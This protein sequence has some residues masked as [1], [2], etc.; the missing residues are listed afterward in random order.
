MNPSPGILDALR[1]GAGRV[2]VVAWLLL[3]GLPVVDATAASAPEWQSERGYRW[4]RVAPA[5]PAKTGFTPLASTATGVTFTN[6]LSD[7]RSVANRNLLSGA[8][9]AAGDV[10]GDGLCDLYYCGLDSD[11]R[12]FRNLGGWKFQDITAGASVACPGQDSTGAAFADLEGDGDLDLLVTALGNGLRLFVNDGRGTFSEETAARGVASRTGGMSMAMA[13]IDGD[14]DLDLYVANYYPTTIRDRPTTRFQVQNLDGRPRIVAVDG[15]STAAPD[16]TN[17]FALSPSGE[18]V[19]FSEPDDLFLNDG[20]GHFSRAS[21]TEGRFLNEEGQRLQ[22]PPRD[23]S[24]S[25]R[26]YDFTGDGAPDIYVCSDLFSPDRIWVNDGRGGFRAL[27]RLA[28]RHTSSFSMGLDFGDLDRDGHSDLYVVDMVSRDL[29]NRK[30]QIAGLSPN[31]SPV[32]LIDNRPQQFQNTLHW[33]RGDGTFA[34]IAYYSGLE[35]TEWSWQPVLLD[36]DLDGYEDVLVPTGMLRDFQNVDVGQHVE[37]AV[38]SRKVSTSE[39]VRL[40]DQYP[41]LHLDNLIFRNRGDLTFEEVGQSW[42]FATPGISQGMALADFDN[43]GDLDLA[44]NNLQ[45]VAGLYRNDGDAPRVAVRLKGLRPNVRGIGAK[46]QVRGG[47]VIQSQEMVCGGRYLSADDTLRVFAAGSPTNQLTL[48][49]TWR[50]GHRSV[51]TN[52]VANAIYEVEETSA[53]AFTPARPAAVSP[54]FAD[55][56]DRLGHAHHEQPFEDFAV[57]PLL[58]RRLSQLGPGVCWTDVDG[59]GWDDLVIG[60]GRGGSLAAYRNDG[61][62]GFAAV[63]VPPFTTPLTR[64]ATAVVGVISTNQPWLLVGSANYEDGLERGAMARTFDL[65]QRTVGDRLPGQRSSTGPLALADVDGDGDLDLFVG[66][67][68]IP[69]RYPEAASSFLF[70]NQA[71]TWQLDQRNVRLFANVGLV[72]GCV[73]TDLDG[74]GDPELVLACEWGPVRVFRND[75]AAFTE[76][77]QELGLASYTGWWNGVTSVDLD[78]DGRLDLVGANWGLNQRYRATPEQPRRIYYGDYLGNGALP[79]VEACFDPALGYY[80][81][82]RDLRMLTMGLPFLQ[83]RYPSHNDFTAVSIDD[84]LG[85]LKPSTRTVE[86]ATLA[87]M[88]FLN[89]GNR[90]EAAPLPREAQL[91]AAFAVCAGDFDG[92]GHEDVFL[93]QNFFPTDL[94]SFRYD[95]GRGLWL[96]GDGR[97][98]LRALSGQESGVLVYGEQRGAALCDFDHDGRVDLVVTQNGAATKLYRNIGA[99]PGLRVRLQGPPANPPGIGAVVRLKH[100]DRFGPAREIHAGSGYWSQDS[101]VLVMG[102]PE[103]ATEVWVRWPGGRTTTTAIPP[104]ALEVTLAGQ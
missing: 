82:E 10:D 24:L 21:F 7:E 17:R 34:E 69:G 88:A 4:A 98:G 20:T 64:D 46:I 13:D 85:D 31:F 79:V 66:G 92:D 29:R 19:E 45:M 76:A 22:E 41:G 100:E 11:N 90:F 1:E 30:I 36:V 93:S 54:F 23:W 68:V 97:G 12:L 51:V 9:V 53:V 101:P 91:T 37:A 33:N 55:V 38:A 27:P 42:G 74:D 99:R 5:R 61:Q 103:R 39:L 6:Q 48:E 96:R 73:F 81:P 86:A 80:V 70:L 104:D 95:S 71:G 8:G 14:G 44:V 28:I 84:F 32:G 78:G 35:A 52:A 58:P 16:L 25:V 63:A 15:R 43:D 3:A 47:P 26:F 56:S 77:T 87:S 65:K 59:D 18:V 75:Q 89:R 67:R 2:R 83:G 60:S 57:Q 62:G 50:S 102:M 72:S 49:V 94:L 40:F